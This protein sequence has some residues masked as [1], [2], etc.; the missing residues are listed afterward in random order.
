MYNQYM[1]KMNQEK[2]VLG[3]PK[4]QNLYNPKFEHDAC[5]IGCITQI[6]GLKSHSIVEDAL[7]VL[8]RLAHRGGAGSIEENGDGAGILTQV[9][10]SFFQSIDLGFELPK[11]GRYGVGMVMLPRKKEERLIIQKKIESLVKSEGQIT[12]GWRYVPVNE[13]VLSLSARQNRPHIRQ[14]FIQA[15]HD[16]S[17]DAF[18][19]RLYVI[20]KRCEHLTQDMHESD[21]NYFYFSS[22][23]TKTIVYKGM[24]TAEQVDGFYLDLQ[25]LNYT[26]AIALVHSRYSTNTF[27]SWERAH[28]YRMLIHNGE[29]NTIRGNLNRMKARQNTMVNDV[30]GDNMQRLLPI[31]FDNGSDSAIFDNTL[32]FLIEA[33]IPLAQAIMMMIPEP[34][35]HKNLPKEL[36]AFYAFSQLHMEAWDG[37]AAMVISDGDHVAAV[38]DRNG[39]RPSRYILTKDNRLIIASEIGVVDINAEDILESGQVKPGEILYV[40]TIHK[41]FIRNH[42]L[43]ASIA[44]A[45]PYQD[46]LDRQQLHLSDL[47]DVECE[48]NIDD[49][50][51]W[52]K[53]FGYTLEER[54]NILLPMAKDGKESIASM[55]HDGP[56]AI[57]SKTEQN[58]FAYFKQIF[59]QVTNPPL[60]ALRERSMMSTQMDLGAIGNLL[61][62]NEMDARRLKLQSPMLS[63]QDFSKILHNQKQGLK[64]KRLYALFTQATEKGL[65]NALQQLFNQADEAIKNGYNLL[66]ISDRAWDDT[67]FPIPSL[68]ALSGLHQYLTQQGTRTRVSLIV[69]SAEAKETHH[70]ALL[71]GYGASAIYPYLAL[72]LVDKF[73]ND[74]QIK[75]ISSMDA[76]NNY[77]EASLQGIVKIMSKMGISTLQS[78]QGAQIFEALGLSNPL[79]DR[80]F[81]NTISRIGGLELSDIA[82]HVQ[83]RIQKSS[84]SEPLDP[85][86]IFRFKKGGE[87]HIFNPDTIKGLQ[88]A[89][90][91]NDYVLFKKMTSE[92]N[93]PNFGPIN[94]RALMG[95]KPSQSISIEEVE[96]VDEIVK[97][98]KTGAMSYGSISPEAHEALAIAMNRLKAKSN[99]GE[100]GEDP[101]RYLSTGLDSKNSAIKQIASGRFGVTSEYLSNAQEIQIKMAQGAKPGEGGQLPGKKVYPW[102]A[103]ARNSTLGVTLISPPPHHDIYSIEDLAQLIH[104][105]KNANSSAKIS[106]KLVS[107]NGVG[108]IAAGVAKGRADG[109]LISGHEGGTGASPLSS[110]QHAGLP[111][112]L[113]LAETHQTLV[114]NN[115]RTRIRLET[116]GKLV[117]GKDVVIAA[118]LGAEEFGFATAPLIALGCVMARVCHLDTCP[119]GIATQNPKRREK[120]IGKPEYVVNFMLFIAQEVREIMAQ[121]GFKTM[122]EMIGQTQVLEQIDFRNKIDLSNILG[123]SEAQY[124]YLSANHGLNKTFDQKVLIPYFKQSLHKGLAQHGSFKINNTNR[125][126]ATQLGHEITKRY[127]G[128][129]LPENHFC[130]HLEGVAG[131]SFGAFIPSG[132]TLRLK[133]YVNDYCGKGLSG[134]RIIV[135]RLDGLKYRAD[136]NSIIGNVAFFGATSGDGYINGCAGERFGV[137]N[138]GAKLIVEGIGNHGC[139][140]MTNG[141]VIII[142]DIGTN[143]AAGM[144]GGIAY[145][146]DPN[147]ELKNRVNLEMVDCVDTS[148]DEKIYLR[149]RLLKHLEFTQSEKAEEILSHW[150]EESKF[151]I[152]VYPKE[153]HNI[154]L[155]ID[156]K[157]KAGM[158]Y[159]EAQIAVFNESMN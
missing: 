12:L 20:R 70:F 131:Q 11:I 24:L 14:L 140:Y 98:F 25:D 27:P 104:D 118:L 156:E 40:D 82:Q 123:N 55:G 108:T 6:D 9:P 48:A 135:T 92:L 50:G 139:E 5:G 153:L 148:S 154:H 23:S 35:E 141:E 115:L 158:N 19:R 61:D 112:E 31:V 106:V 90:M 39:L 132:I 102:I 128:Q 143:F 57:L 113:G 84:N 86:S 43:K 142:G 146:Y 91:K 36:E 114:L 21:S 15:N 150:N 136:K 109:I 85:G 26:S 145:L 129:G 137:R 133:G 100:G 105:M 119:M 17:D 87:A 13:S 73:V 64:S 110:I 69:E 144:S 68:L 81:T 45:K 72:N 10:D 46:W 47:E 147:N 34:W 149:Q 125:T 28:P 41:A 71:I 117:S 94:L 62:M 65:E 83:R 96:S 33:G 4:A 7:H 3:Y 134:G 88:E 130:I 122:N 79:I 76:Q 59:A 111:W 18:E 97:R 151:F 89:V 60:D 120:F 77:L 63:H 93:N 8:R 75:D 74:G 54:I 1:L 155:K 51:L 58:L 152:K 37:P 116:D 99:T 67:H 66:I 138:S 127:G 16:I 95:F 121:L 126:F 53:A 124:G 32:E 107:E 56:L 52:Q 103:K 2:I 30:F 38:L 159:Q 29:I 49:L 80:Y 78:Y 22:L 44:S 101:S 42:E 157:I